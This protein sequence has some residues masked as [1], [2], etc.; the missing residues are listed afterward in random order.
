MNR[1]ANA[2]QFSES[3]KLLL[4]RRLQAAAHTAHRP[5]RRNG[6]RLVCAAAAAALL[7]AGAGALPSTFTGLKLHIGSQQIEAAAVLTLH[8][9][10]SATVTVRSPGARDTHITDYGGALAAAILTGDP[11][12]AATAAAPIVQDRDPA[13]APY[14][15]YAENDRLL[16]HINGYIPIDVTDRLAAGI[17]FT[18]ADSA[19]ERQRAT[20]S[21]TAEDYTVQ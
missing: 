21:G 17:T 3:E 18:Y 16:L 13:A 4:T 6:K 14:T 10:G 20:L 8:T 1:P 2:P 12:A 5:V 11:A 7:V 9:D 19:G 15:V